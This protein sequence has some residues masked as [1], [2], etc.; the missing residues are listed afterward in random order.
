MHALASPHFYITQTNFYI[1][2]LTKAADQRPKLI[3][4]KMCFGWVKVTV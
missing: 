2:V 3:D 1:N 4:A